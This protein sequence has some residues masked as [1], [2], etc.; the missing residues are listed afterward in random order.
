MSKRSVN[1]N[2][3]VIGVVVKDG[4]AHTVFN[5]QKR[6]KA[7]KKPLFKVRFEY[8]DELDTY[9]NQLNNLKRIML[10]GGFPHKPPYQREVKR[11]ITETK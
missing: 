9:I 11:E 3:D 6:F 2:G 4:K 5:T 8:L 1:A 10:E 7:S